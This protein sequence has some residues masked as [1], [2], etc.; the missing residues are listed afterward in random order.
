MSNQKNQ[1]HEP[2]FAPHCCP[3]GEHSNRGGEGVT[4]RTFFGNAG[5]ATLGGIALTGL[6]WKTV[7]AAGATAERPARRR[8]LIVQPIFLYGT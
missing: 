4:R 3:C 7:A 1:K 2:E 5:I 6:T 8:P